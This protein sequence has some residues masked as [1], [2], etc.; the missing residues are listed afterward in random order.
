MWCVQDKAEGSPEDKEEAAKKFADINHGVSC[1]LQT[2]QSVSVTPRMRYFMIVIFTNGSRTAPHR[3]WCDMQRMRCC[4]MRTSEGSMIAMVKRD[5]SSRAGAG[6]M[7]ETFSKSAP[8]VFTELLWLSYA[9][10]LHSARLS[11]TEHAPWHQ[12]S[13]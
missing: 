1:P 6:K 12:C 5:S 3:R 11:R 7:L 4:P 13:L 8:A 10:P 9:W 2:S